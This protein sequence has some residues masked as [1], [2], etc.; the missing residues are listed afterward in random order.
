VNTSLLTI[1]PRPELN[2]LPS[3]APSDEPSP[4][5]LHI[6]ESA[7]NEANHTVNQALPQSIPHYDQPQ[8]SPDLEQREQS[9]P[10][11]VSSISQA[12]PNLH[13]ELPSVKQVQQYKR[14][15]TM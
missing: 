12:H 2:V 5:Q 10:A 15:K 7:L 11:Q 14:Q 1:A 9:L 13:A 8:Q 4:Q 6:Q 3:P